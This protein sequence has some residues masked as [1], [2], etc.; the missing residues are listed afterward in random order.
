MELVL[1]K[2]Y[3]ILLACLSFPLL[4][5]QDEEID[6][7]S[8]M[9][10]AGVDARALEYRA[11]SNESHL[12]VQASMTL[13]DFAS[14]HRARTRTDQDAYEIVLAR[15][16][17]LMREP[18]IV[19]G[20]SSPLRMATYRDDSELV[21]ILLATATPE[22]IDGNDLKFSQILSY[23]MPRSPLQ[24]AAM[25]GH[26]RIATLLLNKRAAIDGLTDS[27]PLMTAS[28]HGHLAVVNVLLARGADTERR[29]EVCDNSKGTSLHMAVVQGHLEVIKALIKH[30]AQVNSYLVA[31][32]AHCVP[33]HIAA[34]H[35]RP[36][37]IAALVKA[38]ARVEEQSGEGLTP[39]H[40][41]A[42]HGHIDSVEAL[43][44]AGACV[45][46]QGRVWYNTPLYYAD[47]EGHAKVVDV[48][49]QAGADRT[50]LHGVQQ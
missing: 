40:I 38:G 17:E 48:L 9:I 46:A 27:T 34:R 28:F 41:A 7:A 36:D 2:R 30:G 32:D 5:M 8:S 1:F 19:D 10:V 49:I 16:Q 37:I 18:A 29:G 13:R 47:R 20:I 14:M 21:K 23:K 24:I 6:F 42:L 44:R 3:I 35:N 26:D 39:L 25:L 4:A 31:G 33:L 15:L 22:Q 45:N 50:C 12:A 43:V 11:R